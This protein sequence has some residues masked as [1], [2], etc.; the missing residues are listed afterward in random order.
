MRDTLPNQAPAPNR[1]ARVPLSG[2]GSLV[3][4]FYAPATSPAAVGEARC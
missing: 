3:H 2:A 4:G 1:R